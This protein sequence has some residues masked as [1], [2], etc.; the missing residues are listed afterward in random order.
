MEL[1]GRIIKV[2]DITTGTSQRTGNQ[3]RKQ[4]FLFGFYEHQS[5]IYER[6][7]CLSVMGD[8]IDKYRLAENDKVKVRIA[9]TCKE[10]NGRYFNE[11][12]TGDINILQ[13]ANAP[14]EDAPQQEMVTNG[15][16]A[17]ASPQNG[18]AAPQPSIDD[19]GDDGLPF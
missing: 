18:D 16:P 8:R 1:E 2:M 11:I 12:L 6:S 5:D 17:V 9:L 4:E 7:I 14:K 3:W 10:Y 13:K 15:N 19:G